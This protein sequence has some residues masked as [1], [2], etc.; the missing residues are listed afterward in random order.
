MH[1]PQDL[2]EWVPEGLA[3]VEAI[4]ADTH[5]H[6]RADTGPDPGSDPGPD[7][8]T[9]PD[10]ASG[11]PA[12]DG[13]DT[14]TGP[15]LLYHFEGFLDAGE[16]GTQLIEELLDDR[17]TGVTVARFDH[18][19]LVDYRARRPVMTFRRDRWT[20]FEAPRL[21]LRLV[22]DDTRRPFLVLSGP[23]PDVEWERFAA[24]VRQIVER[25]RVRLAVG[26]HGIPMG[27][28]HTRPIGLTSHGNRPELVPAR[29]DL[30]DEAQV[31]GSAASLLE[32]RLSE[33]GHD[34]LGIAAHVPHYIA[35]SRYPD[36]AL[37][38]LEALTT[39]T[40]LVLPE[41]AQT[42]RTRS[43]RVRQE[44]DRE[45]AEGDNEL[46]AVVRGLE[47]QYDAVAGAATRGNLVAE[48][49]ELPSAD[50]L[51]AVF[52]RFLAEREGPEEGEDPPPPT[53]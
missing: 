40:G 7:P 22:H 53:P 38:V 20:D 51:G 9:D 52:E 28:P 15:V 4:P 48:P 23:E 6:P 18:D 34:V 30:F 2:Y 16:T 17:R 10:P 21:E 26:F 24:A 11:T 14:P 39:A 5:P 19:R 43:T 25:L 47:Q 46:V 3:M 36:S 13:A 50:E 44:I 27:V 49:A 32:L 12:G 45:L 37:V 42:L 31:P 35:R 41:I 29:N 33:A 1:D 8:D